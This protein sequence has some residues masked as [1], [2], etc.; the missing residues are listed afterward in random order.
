L[1]VSEDA[2][3]LVAV[4][5]RQVAIENHDV[6]GEDPCFVERFVALLGDVDGDALA[7]QAA[8]HR[9]GDSLL[10]LG[11]QNPHGSSLEQHA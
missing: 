5:T 8:G 10:V 11:H 1:L 3:D 2:A 9:I 7:S 6:I 4:H